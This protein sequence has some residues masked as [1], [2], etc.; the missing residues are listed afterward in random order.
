MEATTRVE[1]I[2]QTILDQGPIPR[3]EPEL[4]WARSWLSTSKEPWNLIRRGQATADI[5]RGVTPEIG[6]DDLLVG[7]FSRAPSPRRRTQSWRIGGRMPRALPAPSTASERTWPSISTS[8]CA[9]ASLGCARRST[10]TARASTHP[11]RTTWR[12]TPFTAPA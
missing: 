12:R 1:R 11:D 8:C 5:L 9:W 6:E 3:E 10:S 2:R 7:R 4:F